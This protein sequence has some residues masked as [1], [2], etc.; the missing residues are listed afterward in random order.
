LVTE[1]EAID[2]FIHDSVAGGTRGRNLRALVGISDDGERV[3]G[4][5]QKKAGA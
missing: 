4:L 3:L 5:I 1:L 2:V